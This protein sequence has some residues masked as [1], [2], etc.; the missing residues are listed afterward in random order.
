MFGFGGN[1]QQVDDAAMKFLEQKIATACGSAV[2]KEFETSNLVLKE[3]ESKLLQKLDTI[4]DKVAAVEKR[5]DE[6][7]EKV[8]TMDSSTQQQFTSIREEIQEQKRQIMRMS[9]LV[10]MGVPESAEGLT[11]AKDI[12]KI[13]APTWGGTLQDIR[14]GDPS[15]RKPRPLRVTF[16]TAA[17]KNLALNNCKKLAGMEL[18]KNI[19]IRKDL[20]K[21]QQQEWKEKASQ[22]ETRG[23]KKRRHDNSSPSAQPPQKESR[24]DTGDGN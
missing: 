15:G 22:R 23:S 13:V 5:Q 12:M 7:E 8:V 4:V 24:M 21:L 19:S 1:N 16:S 14:I 6:L 17:E 9:N 2:K 11:T 3:F 20:T 10:L 18:Y